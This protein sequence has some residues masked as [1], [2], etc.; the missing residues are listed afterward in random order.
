MASPRFLKYASMREELN[1]I[2]VAR[3]KKSRR[4][5]P[6]SG[7][8]VDTEPG[9]MEVTK[10]G[11]VKTQIKRRLLSGLY[12]AGKATVKGPQMLGRAGG[13]VLR[14][15]GGAVGRVQRNVRQGVTAF[16]TGRAQALGKFRKQPPA[17]ADTPAKTTAIV[18]ASQSSPSPRKGKKKEKGG[19]T[20]GKAGLIG[21]GLAVGGTALGMSGLMKRHLET[22]Y[23]RPLPYQPTSEGGQ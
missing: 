4:P 14:G 20:W 15:A 23:A 21:G 12:S 18:P 10:V 6:K 17:V 16:Q 8:V 2:S 3:V 19:M 1:K 11:G 5:I 7:Q 22:G 9:S 13:A